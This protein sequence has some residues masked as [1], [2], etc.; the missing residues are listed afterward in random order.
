MILQALFEYADE[1]KLVD[2]MEVK[3]R[4]VHL[5]L[6]I[7][8]D[9][10]IA[11]GAPWQSLTRTVTDPKKKDAQKEEPGRP[12]WMPEFPGVNSGGKANFL[13]E[14]CDKVLGSMASPANRSPTMAKTPP[15]RSCI[16]GSASPTPTRR[17][18]IPAWPPS[19]RSAIATCRRP[20]VETS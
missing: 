15:R 14:A 16:S 8:S 1:A 12:F 5:V 18:P 4:L 20:K 9:G 7:E 11:A 6:T 13:A 17:R 3:E 2:A 19:S 10:S